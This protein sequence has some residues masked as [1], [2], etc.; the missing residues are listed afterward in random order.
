SRALGLSLGAAGGFERD[1]LAEGRAV[2]PAPRFWEETK[3]DPF[4]RRIRP[5]VGRVGALAGDELV[6]RRDER[7]PERRLTG[8]W[9]AAAAEFRHRPV[10]VADDVR[11]PAGEVRGAA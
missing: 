4:A 5:P 8:P 2:R 11:V 6:S 3:R 7:V 9:I 1:R 10:G